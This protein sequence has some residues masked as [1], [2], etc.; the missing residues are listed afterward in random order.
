MFNSGTLLVED[1]SSAPGDAC[2]P[3]PDWTNQ[4]R[5]Y[6]PDMFNAEVGWC[7][8]T[9]L[10]ACNRLTR[11][12]RNLEMFPATPRV[13]WTLCTPRVCQVW[14]IKHFRYRKLPEGSFELVESMLAK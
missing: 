10:S 3:K 5:C 6:T 2:H 14:Q 9:A 8:V 1:V 7:Y 12:D 4:L 11:H 13:K